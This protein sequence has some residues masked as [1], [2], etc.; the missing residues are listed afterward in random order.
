MAAANSKDNTSNLMGERKS[1]R[2][3]SSVLAT[4]D[5][6]SFNSQSKYHFNI[7]KEELVHKILSNNLEIED[8][9]KSFERLFFAWNFKLYIYKLL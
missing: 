2:M 6:I 9:S 7:T 5:A 1:S 8:P 4:F 3:L